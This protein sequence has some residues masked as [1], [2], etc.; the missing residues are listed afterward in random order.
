LL[1]KILKS[2]LKFE[3]SVRFEVLHLRLDAAIP[4]LLPMLEILSK[5][6]KANAVKGRQQFSLNLC[7]VSRLPVL[8]IMLHPWEPNKSQEAGSGKWVGR[9]VG[10]NHYFVFSQKEGVLLTLQGVN[11]NRW[12]PSTVFPLKTLDNVSSNGRGTR[13]AA[14]SRRDSSLKGTN[15][16]KLDNY[17][18]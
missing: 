5:I 12:R 7:N 2:L 6:F 9:G 3:T 16:S 18:K 14:S 4:A 8:Q 15:V 13:I 1:K 10:Y 11:E 17:F